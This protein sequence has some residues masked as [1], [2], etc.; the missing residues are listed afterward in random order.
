MIGIRFQISKMKVAAGRAGFYQSFLTLCFGLF[1]Q[2]GAVGYA[3]GLDEDPVLHEFEYS[4]KLFYPMRDTDEASECSRRG[5]IVGERFQ[6]A[7]TYRVVSTYCE[8]DIIRND[9]ASLIIR[10]EAEKPV[11]INSTYPREV[12][13]AERAM[14]SS[15]ADCIANYEANESMYR[16]Q[17]ELE[18]FVS[19]CFP[20][21][22]KLSGGDRYWSYRIEAV[23]EGKK[24]FNVYNFEAY[25]TQKPCVEGICKDIVNYY[26]NDETSKLAHLVVHRNLAWYEPTIYAYSVVP[27]NADSE[28][29]TQFE[30]FESCQTTSDLV[31]A[32]FQKNEKKILTV[33]CQRPTSTIELNIVWLHPFTEFSAKPFAKYPL[34]GFHSSR[35]LC[36]A[37]LPAPET[38]GTTKLAFCAY[39]KN[40]S[41]YQGTVI[42]L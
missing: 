31:K 16:A 1:T 5:V 13:T 42:A 26:F 34:S 28:H 22:S 29:K 10:Y 7:S 35:T 27:Q 38:L 15:Q 25:T 9:Y 8:P 18:P 32:H 30:S 6:A 41:A 2:F 23:G 39:D 12:I 40:L 33:F 14:Y 37:A 11:V 3:D 24:H 21:R 20:T 17:V 4:L 36:E 19:Y